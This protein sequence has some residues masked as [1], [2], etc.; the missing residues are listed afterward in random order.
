M[1]ALKVMTYFKV[2]LSTC[3]WDSA[4]F[5]L[6]LG[7]QPGGPGVPSIHSGCAPREQH[8]ETNAYPD[9]AD[10]HSDAEHRVGQRGGGWPRLTSCD[11]NHAALGPC[12]SPRSYGRERALITL[13]ANHQR[14]ALIG[15]E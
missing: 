15:I 8:H 10:L 3:N 11:L 12:Y 13:L 6:H 1:E 14:P 4:F 9:S 5:M 7:S 2:S